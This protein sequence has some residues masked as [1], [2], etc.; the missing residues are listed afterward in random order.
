MVKAHTITDQQERFAREYIVDRNGTA[1]AVRAGYSEATASQA[2]TRLL[3]HEGIVAFIA[4]LTEKRNARVE[5]TPA[6]LL[7]ELGRLALADVGLAFNPDGTMRPI[8]EIPEDV[9]RCLSG[10][11]VRQDDSGAS[12]V[13]A[14]FVDKAKGLELAMKHLGMLTEKLEHS[15]PDGGALQIV[16]MTEKEEQ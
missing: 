14:K 8:H 6:R 7:E 11:E 1:A 4:N 10:L 5:L 15:G 16:V 3:K 9:R 12:I 2:A 13:K